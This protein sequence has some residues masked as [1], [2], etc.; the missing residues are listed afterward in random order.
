M[1][2]A[3]QK[4]A[5]Q[6]HRG[7]KVTGKAEMPSLHMPPLCTSTAAADELLQNQRGTALLGAWQRKVGVIFGS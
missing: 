2:I 7:E 4:P 6:E 3:C 5:K 1:P